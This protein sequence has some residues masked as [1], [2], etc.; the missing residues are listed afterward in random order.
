MADIHLTSELVATMAAVV[1]PVTGVAVAYMRLTM[2]NAIRGLKLDLIKEL[3]GTYT[4]RGECQ[5]AHTD[6]RDRLVH[7]ESEI[8]EMGRHL[9]A[10]PM[11]HR[12]IED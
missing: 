11:P 9:N 10:R 5:L 12:E 4:R 2:S 6:I 7:M 3:N 1:I 8:T